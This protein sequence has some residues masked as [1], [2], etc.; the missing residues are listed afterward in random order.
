MECFG[1]FQ[2][3][4]HYTL[5]T[6][7]LKKA[8]CRTFNSREAANDYMYRLCAKF[9]LHI[10]EVYDDKHNKTYKCNDG[11]KFFIQRAY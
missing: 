10:V 2:A 5:A 4:H 1:L 9:G 6:A 3:A 11:I 7:G 8:Y